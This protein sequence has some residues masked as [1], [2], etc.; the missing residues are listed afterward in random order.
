MEPLCGKRKENQ[1]QERSRWLR[2]YWFRETPDA[3]IAHFRYS[4]SLAAEA[5][6][7]ELAHPG[8]LMRN[9]ERRHPDG[10]ANVPLALREFSFMVVSRCSR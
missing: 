5:S 10:K 8:V 4:R 2:P 3:R 1:I 9:L 7:Y 6:S